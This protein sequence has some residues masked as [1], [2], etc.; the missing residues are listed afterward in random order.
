MNNPMI[1][2]GLALS[3][4]AACGGPDPVEMPAPPPE[5]FV[6]VAE[7]ERAEAA[8][9]AAAPPE[10]P[11]LVATAAQATAALGQRVR[12]LGTADDAKLSAVV[13]S[14]ALVV[15]CMGRGADGLLTESRWPA[16]VVGQAVAVTGTLEQSEQFTATVAPDGAISQGTEGP[17]LAVVDFELQVVGSDQP[18]LVEPA[19]AEPPQ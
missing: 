3:M 9:A 14:E 10:V 12:L 7:I 17:I 19:V 16:D 13:Q 5:P 8:A 6:T 1:L 4:A 11:V 2:S 15:Y 18:E